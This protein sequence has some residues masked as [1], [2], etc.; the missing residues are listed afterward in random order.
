MFNLELS[1]HEVLHLG[2]ILIESA[3]DNDNDEAVL[4]FH[5]LLKLI[6]KGK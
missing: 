3:T 4:L 1:A 6:E 5:H 2:K